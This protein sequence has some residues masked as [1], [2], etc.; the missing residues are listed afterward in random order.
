MKTFV[1]GF[2]AAVLGIIIFLAL[3]IGWLEL[4][5]PTR[6]SSEDDTAATAD[7]SGTGDTA[8]GTGSGTGATSGSAS[9]AGG[10]ESIDPAVD[11]IGAYNAAT[12]Q[13][14]AD[15][16]TF[17]SLIE[18]ELAERFGENLLIDHEDKRIIITY[19]VDD[20][21]TDLSAGQA[22]SSTMDLWISQMEEANEVCTTY[23]NQIVGYGIKNAHITVNM[24]NER[25]HDQIILAFEDG[26]MRHDGLP[27]EHLAEQIL[28]NVPQTAATDSA[29]SSSTQ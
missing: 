27:A 18:P 1:K 29:D 14:N 9:N 17:L 7:G 16:D 20:L 24:L 6:A 21:I 2:A 26:R 19:W 28:R 12:A 23:Y 5:S 11:P 15:F 10:A 25:N 22:D 13:Q 3:L 8:S 4:T